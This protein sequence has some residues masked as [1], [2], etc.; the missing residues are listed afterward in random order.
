MQIGSDGMRVQEFYT[1]F[2]FFLARFGPGNPLFELLEPVGSGS[3]PQILILVD[4]RPE[5]GHPGIF[6]HFLYAETCPLGPIS[7]LRPY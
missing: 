7:L 3:H 5:T 6:G 4:F 1:P 2:F